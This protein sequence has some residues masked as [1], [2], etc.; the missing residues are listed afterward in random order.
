[1]ALATV[2]EA[3]ADLRA[4][5]MLIVVD[6]ADRENEGDLVLPA[7][8]VT[9]E[10]VNFMAAQARGL[11]CV[12][13]TAERLDDLH[14]PLM[15][16]SAHNTARHGTAFAVSVDVL[17]NAT[18]GISAFDR[19]ATIR[20][21]VD[22]AT[23]PEDLARPGHIF[24][25]RAHPQG[26]RGRAGHTEAS[27]ELARL[28]GFSPAGI[29]CEILAEDGTMARLPQLESFAARHHLRIVSVADLIEY[30]QGRS[31]QE[32]ADRR[33]EQSQDHLSD[34]PLYRAAQTQLPTP[35]GEFTALAYQVS[36]NCSLGSGTADGRGYL[37]LV[38]GD[39][40][41]GAPVLTRVQSECVTGEVFGSRRCDCGEQLAIA[42]T[43]IEREGRGVLV[44][45]R[46]HE[47][48]GIGLANKLRAY[49]LQDLGL[50]T[51]EA[52][53]RL[54]FPADARDYA[55]AAQILRDLGVRRVRLLTN[56]PA[57]VA[58][59][60]AAGLDIVERVPLEVAPNVNNQRYLKTKRVK[61][62]HLLELC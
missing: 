8:Q 57:K 45:V 14:L 10:A 30:L 42:L 4:G 15:L 19:A 36:P 40:S 20:A 24:P 17:R 2:E 27:V 12:A 3:L 44:Y 56:N 54:G 46:E 22:P 21:L 53:E 31:T 50:D 33:G 38:K 35:Y 32:S 13:L 34:L 26:V 52:N 29:L 55:A 7:E 58:A 16:S 11:I 6:D 48:R 49:A 1:M 39:V 25:L 9:P 47:G 18:T 23:Q 62:G 43:Q 59:L 28:A 37:V 61:M 41:G 51:V 60:E 5:R